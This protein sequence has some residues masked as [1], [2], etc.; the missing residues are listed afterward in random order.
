MQ[1]AY[2][3]TVCELA[4]SDKNVIVMTADSGTDFDKWLQRE[5]PEQYFDMG[6]SECNMVNFAAG[7][8]T[9][10][11]IPF[12]QANG[13]F[14]AYRAFEFIRI[15]LCLQKSNVKVVGVASGLSFSNLGPTHHTTEDIGVLR[16]LPGITILCPCSPI[17]VSACIKYAYETEGPVYLRLEMNGEK[18]IYTSNYEF[19]FGKCIEVYAGNDAV[20]FVMGSIISEAIEAA[21]MLKKIG[22]G[23]KVVNVHTLKPISN[24]EFLKHVENI[25][26]VCT[27][28]EHNIYGGLGSI[29]AEC[30]CE[31]QY[32]GKWYRFGLMDTFASGYG[33]VNELREKNGLNKEVIKNKIINLLMDKEY[34]IYRK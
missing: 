14:L 29:L 9:C 16:T 18:E 32:Q 34:E 13:A 2:M 7:M 8:S 25:S 11:K 20:I 10:G 19:Q 17:E 15:G 22:I 12:I 33:S 1:R 27:L 5:V 26:V 28:E 30:L 23:L 3:E 6:L 24:Q 31:E 21:K 4:Q